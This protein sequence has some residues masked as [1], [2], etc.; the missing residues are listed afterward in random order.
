MQG[1]WYGI[2]GLGFRGR[3]DDGFRA[4][5]EGLACGLFRV[6]DLHNGDMYDSYTSLVCVIPHHAWR[7]SEF[8][9]NLRD[10]QTQ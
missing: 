9:C 4:W 2:S 6:W 10:I 1:F 7:F 8:F 3:L 5:A